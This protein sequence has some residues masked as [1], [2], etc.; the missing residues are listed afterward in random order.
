[1]PGRWWVLAAVLC[2]G[3][4]KPAAVSPESLLPLE[5]EGGWRRE[6][7]TD[8]PV[9][10]APAV[11][12]QLGLERVFAARYRGPGEIQATVYRMSTPEAA[13]EMAQ[14]WPPSPESVSIYEQRHSIVIGWRATEREALRK[15]VRAL[16]GHLK[17]VRG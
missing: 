15:F 7:I 4:S 16:G 8:L 1:M 2:C 5:L 10:E 9:A 12:R 13:F 11:A 6:A 14:K 17:P 3:C